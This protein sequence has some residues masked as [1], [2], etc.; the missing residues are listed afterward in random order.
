[1]PRQPGMFRLPSGRPL[2]MDMTTYILGRLARLLPLL[3]AISF[4]SFVII[5][6]S[7]SDPAEVAIR[8]NDITPTPELLAETRAQM[9]LDQPFLTRYLRWLGHA[10]QGDLG[11]RYVDGKSV[12]G[13][14][15][16][17]LPPTLQLA[18][19]AALVILVCSVPAALISACFE[20]RAPDIVLRGLIFF[21]ASV[22]AFWAGLL[23]IWLFAVH[24]D[25][26]PLGGL[27]EAASLILPAVT[28]ALPYIST[29]TRLLRSSILQTKQENFVLYART[30]GRGR[31][32]ILRHI[33]RNSLQSSLAG[34]G[35]SLP[36]L[37]AGTFVVECIFAWSGL[38]RLCVSAIFNRDFPVIQAYI[39]LMAVLFT[40]S[41]LCMDVCAALVDPRL[42]DRRAL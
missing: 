2:S 41:N 1:M 22:P 37:I 14:M 20:G 7:P 33:F 11:V 35:M 36:K 8:V 23:L 27:D 40:L 24:W 13:E 32:A 10:L 16:R 30:C 21:S 9:G 29:Y 38:G 42:R 12:A 3:L 28:L 15:A 5:Q 19:A 39:L 17:A 25:L 6:L 4:L 26:L 34:L 31:G 18:G